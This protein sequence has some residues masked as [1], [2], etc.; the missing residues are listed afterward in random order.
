MWIPIGIMGWLL[1][2]LLA[3]CMVK[4]WWVN[5]FG[6]VDELPSPP[7]FVLGGVG[8][9]IGVLLFITFSG[10]KTSRDG[11]KFNRWR[12]KL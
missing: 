4:Y 6:D 2:G 10:N 8:Y 12:L 5:R 7:I 1:F 11:K 3:R 9:L